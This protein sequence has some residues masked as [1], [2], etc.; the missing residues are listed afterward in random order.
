MRRL[1]L[2]SRSRRFATLVPATLIVSLG[3]CGGGDATRDTAAAAGAGTPATIVDADLRDVGTYELTMDKIDK[4]L[5]ATRNMALAMKGLTPE[6]REKLKARGDASAS[7]DDYAAQIESE[8]IARD[9]VRRAGLSSREFATITMAY[10]QA[11]MAD[12]V[13]QMRPD[14]KNADSIAREMKAN[15]AN[16]R[17]VRENRAAL[18][19]KFKALEAEMKAMG[20]DQ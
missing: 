3:G 1:A 16:V 19:A 13:L 6:Q 12:A 2:P 4:Y 11:G 17:F 10:L 9:A 15:P 18:D 5:A 14:I 20:A 7:L 8:P